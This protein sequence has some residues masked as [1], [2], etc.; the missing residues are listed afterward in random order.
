MGDHHI[1]GE[2]ESVSSEGGS[3]V[4]QNE[5]TL[6]M[7]QRIFELQRKLEQVRNLA[8]LSLK[9]NTPELQVD[10]HA[11]PKPQA[12]SD[13]PTTHLQP[14]IPTNVQNLQNA[15]TPLYVP[16]QEPKTPPIL[17]HK[18]FR[19]QT[20]STIMRLVAITRIQSILKP[21]HQTVLNPHSRTWRMIIQCRL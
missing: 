20:Y 7:E 21:F 17:P 14:Q 2:K 1:V 13:H 5:I 18:S 11:I 15:T 8:K 10:S 6:K 19:I 9:L 12:P 4:G 3:V 16:T